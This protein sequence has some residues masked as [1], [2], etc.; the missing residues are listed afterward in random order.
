MNDP[1]SVATAASENPLSDVYVNAV[2]QQHGYDS[3]EAVIARL[4]QWI[5]CNGRK[6]AATLLIYEAYKALSK[7][8]A[9][10]A[11]ERAA[12]ER[13]QRRTGLDELY[14]E[15][16]ATHG[17]YMWTATKEAWET[18]QA[19]AALA[20]A[21]V[22]DVPQ[23]TGNPE[24]DRLIGRLM[25]S[26]PDFDDCA[27]AA[28]L[29]RDLASTPVAGEAVYTLRVRGA[30]QAWTPTTAAFSIPDGEHQLFLSPAAPPASE[31]V[32]DAVQFVLKTFKAS[33]EQG[34]RT[35]DRQFAI[36]ILEQALSAPPAAQKESRDA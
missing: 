30:I 3:V 33:E 12:F 1:K 26:D 10:V 9:P 16:H 13:F 28:R 24:A 6:N 27:A 31:A 8:R 20:S 25:S 23:D 11:D 32:L 34:Y 19:R 14:L 2:I 22:A 15:R 7:L 5:G 29:I 17:Q 36:S 21:P 4:F 35:R 18:W